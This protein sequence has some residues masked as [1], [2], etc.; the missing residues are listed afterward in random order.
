MLA[1]LRAHNAGQIV[2]EL[3][4][5]AGLTQRQLAERLGKPQSMVARWE[6]GHDTPR[7]DSLWT[8]AQACGVEVDLTTRRHDEVDRAQIRAQL[9]RRPSE[10]LV[11]T[12]NV[13]M[14][15]AV[16]RRVS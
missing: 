1:T 12:E 13:A 8:I 6:R 10:R 14:L 16:A 4:T 5:S 2:R 15:K 3:R 11:N 9:A 7:L